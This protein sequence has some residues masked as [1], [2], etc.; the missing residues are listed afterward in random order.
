M[1][2]VKAFSI[3]HSVRR[4]LHASCFLLEVTAR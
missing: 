2:K 3:R 4:E 1:L